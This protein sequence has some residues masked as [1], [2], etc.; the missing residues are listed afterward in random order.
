MET[1]L[2]PQIVVIGNDDE[3]KKIVDILM[4]IL[5]GEIQKTV[6]ITQFEDGLKAWDI[7]YEAGRQVG[8]QLPNLIIA[9]WDGERAGGFS[10]LQMSRTYLDTAIPV[11]LIV[12]KIE[13]KDQDSIAKYEQVMV[14]SWSELKEV[15]ETLLA[16]KP[17]AG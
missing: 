15:L 5:S 4:D 17:S 1:A 7:L 16:P 12:E 10:V 13:R 2:K 11:C 14:V 6:E 8:N 9:P 3:R